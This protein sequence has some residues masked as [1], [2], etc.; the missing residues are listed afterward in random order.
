MYLNSAYCILNMHSD[1][2]LVVETQLLQLTFAIGC[3]WRLVL[4][5]YNLPSPTNQTFFFSCAV[6]FFL[7]IIPG[8]RLVVLKF[9][10]ILVTP[11]SLPSPGLQVDLSS[12]RPRLWT[13][14]WWYKAPASS[15]RS[16]AGSIAQSDWN[17]YFGCTFGINVCFR[18]GT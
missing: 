5:A 14:Q 18:F 11:L 4:D 7:W 10:P 12:C 16:N 8:L 1:C 3:W 9:C 6:L 2:P 17:P 15:L 13:L